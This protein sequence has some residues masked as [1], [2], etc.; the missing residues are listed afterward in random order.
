MLWH[1]DYIE[2]EAI[3]DNLHSHFRGDLYK[4]FVGDHGVSVLYRNVPQP[5]SEVPLPI[6]WNDAQITAV[7]VLIESSMINSPAWREYICSIAHTSRERDDHS[8]FFSVILE[9]NLKFK[10]DEQ[11][12][13]WDLWNASG[14]D[15]LERLIADL[16]HEFCRM[17][18]HRLDRLRQPDD[19]HSPF[20]RYLEKIEIFISHSKHDQDGEKIAGKIR[21]WI[22]QNS[23][24][25][26]FFDVYD[27]PP[28]TSFKDV[29]QLKI[30]S[31]AVIAVQTDSYS[32]REWCRREVIEAKRR[33]VPMIVVDCLR[34][35]DPQSLPYLGNVPVVRQDPNYP[36]KVSR[37]QKISSVVLSEI[38]RSW[39]W[40]FRVEGLRHHS[41]ATIFTARQPELLTLA[42]MVSK[43]GSQKAE[44][45]HPEPKLSADE[46]NLFFAIAPYVRILT[47]TDWIE[48]HK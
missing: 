47:I 44:I 12:L 34:D 40:D 20:S 39:L 32:S 5:K 36:D 8:S 38:F 10:L 19:A 1:S 9:S 14:I 29:L 42:E 24:L 2:G 17:I 18:R 31:G 33:R 43:V 28:G 7:V 16:T 46:H 15:R 3:A 13:R 27:I 4:A 22:H 21:D 45:V 35:M 41:S 26:S 11:A 25:S 48:V 30:G 37:I 6:D 23:A